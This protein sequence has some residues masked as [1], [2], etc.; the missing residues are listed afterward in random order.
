MK[1]VITTANAGPLHSF[2]GVGGVYQV[3][4]TCFRLLLPPLLYHCFC[5]IF[6][7]CFFFLFL[8][9]SFLSWSSSSCTAETATATTVGH[10]HAPTLQLVC[11]HITGERTLTMDEARLQTKKAAEASF[12]KMRR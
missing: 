4:F 2:N 9:L 6:Y 5:F 7:V 3:S 10:I 12:G 11:N 1:N 8:V